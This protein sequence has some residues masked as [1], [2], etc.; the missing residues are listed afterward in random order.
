MNTKKVVEEGIEKVYEKK[1][2]RYFALSVVKAVGEEVIKESGV[3]FIEWRKY[4]SKQ[5]EEGRKDKKGRVILAYPEWLEAEQRKR[6]D[7]IM[8]ELE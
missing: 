2:F 6:L 7:K 3:N 8:K 5:Y 4:V 1:E